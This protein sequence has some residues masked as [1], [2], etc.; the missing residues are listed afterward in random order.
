M[1]KFIGEDFMLNS[2]TARLLYFE[3]AKNMPVIDYHCHINPKDIAEDKKYNNISEIWLTC[4]DHYKWRAIRSNGYGEEYITGNA[5][6]YEK[7][8]AWANTLPKCIGSPLYVWAHFELKTYFDYCGNLNPGTLDEVWNL[9]NE[10][11]KNISARQIIKDSKVKL[12]CTTDDPADNLAEHRKILEENRN[13]K[14]ETRVLPAFRPDKGLHIEKPGF[15]EYIE[16]LSEASGIEIKDKNSLFEAYIKRLDYFVS[17]GCKTAD[18]GFENIPFKRETSDINLDG[19]LKKALNNK[20]FMLSQDE[21]DIYKTELILFLAEEYYKRN[22]VMQIHF[23]VGRNNSERLFKLWGADAGAD[24]I[25]G[26]N[27]IESLSKL[28]NQLDK[29]NRLPKVILYSINPADNA[30]LVALMGC[31]Q[32][33]DSALNIIPGGAGKMQHGSAWWFNDTNFGMRE[34][35]TNLA[36]GGL[37]ANFIGMLTDSRSFLSYTRHDYFRRILCDVVGAYAENGE[38]PGDLEYLSEIISDICYN[39]TNNYFGFGL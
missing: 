34:Q 16:K 27:C 38:Y 8:S 15:S 29:N 28:L 39:N 2:E 37:L 1:K 20:D 25:G 6:D 9:C 17:L 7:F 24:S 14:F 18:N 35:L 22:L 11:L 4:G 3:T 30:A 19:V 13:Q 36:N 21:T 10:K 26:Y 32:N 31:F 23:G 33:N 12:I 5:S